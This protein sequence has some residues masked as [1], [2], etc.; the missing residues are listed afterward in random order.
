MNNLADSSPSE[1]LCR[2]DETRD[3]MECYV[4]ATAK[5]VLDVGCAHG[6]FGMGLLKVRSDLEIWGI[7]PVAAGADVAAQRLTKVLNT[8]IED[9]VPR[10]PEGYFDCITFN[11]VLEHLTDP[12]SVLSVLKPS[13]SPG[14]IVVASIPNIRYFKVIKELLQEADF[15]YAPYGV[16]DKTHLRFFTRKSM[17]RLFTESGYRVDRID[18]IRRA[19]FPWKFG[20][21]NLLC[22]NAFDDARYERF[23]IVASPVN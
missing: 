21:L 15:R 22:R 19:A 8:T 14:A 2:Y 20:L 17:Q 10:L 13:M 11:D 7:E 12:W 4:P 9:A 18:G 3:D 5:R 16:L 6:R 1:S 23:A